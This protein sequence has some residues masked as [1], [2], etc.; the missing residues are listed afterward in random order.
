MKKFR[1]SQDSMH[2][3][4]EKTAPFTDWNQYLP[5][6]NNKKAKLHDITVMET[7]DTRLT[8]YKGVFH[9][10][11]HSLINDPKF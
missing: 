9:Q 11:G 6:G 7:I 1:D 3:E 2:D 5:A 10:Y 8:A 4:E